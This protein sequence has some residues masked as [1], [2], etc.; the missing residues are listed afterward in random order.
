[1]FSKLFNFD[2]SPAALTPTNF[3]SIFLLLFL[4]LFLLNAL[5]FF[6][7]WFTN[8]SLC[9]KAENV[10]NCLVVAEDNLVWEPLKN[11]HKDTLSF[12]NSFDIYMAE[13][14]DDNVCNSASMDNLVV[15]TNRL[16]MIHV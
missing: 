11:V 13:D 16:E 9:S 12:D 8:F 2:E 7:G 1:M 6:L 10:E 14:L 15:Y 4:T 5:L 3:K